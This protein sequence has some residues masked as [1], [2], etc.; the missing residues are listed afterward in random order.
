MTVGGMGIC[1]G[2]A[3]C[4]AA[5]VECGGKMERATERAASMLAG[6][7]GAVGGGWDDPL[8]GGGVGAGAAG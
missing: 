3:G 2:T 5:E 7:G 1:V 8:A 6:E 4:C